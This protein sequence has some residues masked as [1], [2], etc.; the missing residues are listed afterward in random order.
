MDATEGRPIVEI[1]RNADGSFY[2]REYG[3]KLRTWLT[4]DELIPWIELALQSASREAIPPVDYSES[5]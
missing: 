5:R 3:P 2:R 1:G 4:D